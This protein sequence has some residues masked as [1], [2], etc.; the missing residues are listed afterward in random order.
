MALFTDRIY[1]KFTYIELPNGQERPGSGL[2][3]VAERLAIPFEDFKFAESVDETD[4]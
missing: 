4:R 1:L 2:A 3:G